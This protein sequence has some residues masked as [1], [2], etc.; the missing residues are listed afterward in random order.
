MTEE[1]SRAT[2]SGR[3]SSPGGKPDFT[4]VSAPND[5][6]AIIT[7]QVTPE[8]HNALAEFLARIGKGEMEQIFGMKVFGQAFSEVEVEIKTELVFQFFANM[9][10]PADIQLHGKNRFTSGRSATYTAEDSQ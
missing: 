6:R 8:V 7:Y 4:I 2:N 3:D 9:L 1:S 10:L 5:P